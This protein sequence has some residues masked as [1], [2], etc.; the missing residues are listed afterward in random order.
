MDTTSAP[1]AIRLVEFGAAWCGPCRAFEPVLRSFG[2]RHP[3][4]RIDHVDV[5]AHP[6]LAAAYDIRSMPTTVVFRGDV[7]VGR[8]IGAQPLQAF[9]AAVRE[10]LAEAV[11]A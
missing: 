9:E 3:A 11:A 10:I 8:V 5:D 2:E 6:E 1:D 4:V 7:P